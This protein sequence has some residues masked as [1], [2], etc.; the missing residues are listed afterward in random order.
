MSTIKT[1]DRLVATEE[2]VKYVAGQYDTALVRQLSLAHIG[3]KS[4]GNCFHGCITLTVLDLSHN[5]LPSFD[6][7]EALSETLQR[8]NLSH[9]RLTSASGIGSLRRLEVLQL[10]GNNLDDAVKL[11][12]E[13]DQLLALRSL[14]LREYDGTAANPLCAAIDSY[15]STITKRYPKLRNLDGH[16]FCHDSLNPQR[17]DAGNDD[18]YVLPPSLPW[19]PSSYFSTKGF[20]NG[21]K[22]GVAAE[23]LFKAA[24]EECRKTLADSSK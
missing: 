3:L 18:E 4:L 20:D 23:Q 22:V 10:A 8:L 16:Y 5:A 19:L 6:G 1:D 12:G 14:S 11:F 13:L 17:I 9:N 21:Q 7:V 2:L 24:V 15:G